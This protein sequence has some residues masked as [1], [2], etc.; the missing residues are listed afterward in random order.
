MQHPAPKNTYDASDPFGSMSGGRTYPHTGSDYS[1]GSGSTV[2]SVADGVVYHTGFNAGNGNYVC[3]YL[4]GHDWDGVQGGTYIAYLHLSEIHVQEGTTVAEGQAIGLSG[5]TGTN[6]RGA[7]L[8]ITL[9][10]SDRAYL[11]EGDKVDP[12]AWIEA[13]IG[14]S[15]PA[16]TPTPGPTPPPSVDYVEV[17]TLLAQRGYYTG[18]IDGQFGPQSWTAVQ[19]C[20]GDAG[21]YDLNYLDGVPGTN[22]YIGMQ[23]YAQKNDNYRYEIDGILGPLTWAGFTQS[24]REDAPKPTPPAPPVEP[25]V[26]PEKPETVVPEKPEPPTTD[27]PSK[28]PTVT[29][30]LTPEEVQA[31]K[32]QI[33]SLPAADLGVIITDPK[34]RKVAYALYSL[35]SLLVTNTAVAYAALGTSFPPALT[36]AIA[37]IGNLAVPFSALA[38]ANAGSKK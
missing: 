19:L 31:Q 23:M 32:D 5:N 2:E 25:P 13:R 17:Q 12:Y 35:A 15:A 8:H 21:F 26:A 6:S 14:Q 30:P 38:I 11:G 3:C 16:P 7:H 28:E 1:I 34:N 37:V 36:V 4:P 9:S 29:A 22:T 10:N 33:A 27:A 20:C 24:L 18:E